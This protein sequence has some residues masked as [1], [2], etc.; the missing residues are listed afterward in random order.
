MNIHIIINTILGLIFV[1][2]GYVVIKYKLLY[3]IAG[4]EP[5]KYD[6]DMLSKICGSHLLFSGFM[7]IVLSILLLFLNPYNTT[8]NYLVIYSLLMIDMVIMVY[9][10]EKYARK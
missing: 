6:D 4:Y 2:C 9:E 3:L 1:I 10:C 5:G 8:A 7:I